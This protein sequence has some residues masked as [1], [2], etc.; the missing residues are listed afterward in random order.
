MFVLQFLSNNHLSVLKIMML[1][2]HHTWKVKAHVCYRKCEWDG[3]MWNWKAENYESLQPQTWNI[4]HIFPQW[5]QIVY[6]YC[7]SVTLSFNNSNINK[8]EPKFFRVRQFFQNKITWDVLHNN[9]NF[10]SIAGD[11][12]VLSNSWKQS[13]CVFKTNSAKL[14]YTHFSVC[15]SAKHVWHEMISCVWL[16]ASVSVLSR[17]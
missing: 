15:S 10:L 5:S 17:N 3:N 11:C 14:K 8:K 7:C 13:W 6:Q 12:L 9:S 1:R 16:W 2:P 4:C